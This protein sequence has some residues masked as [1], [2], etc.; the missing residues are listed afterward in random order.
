MLA[1]CEGEWLSGWGLFLFVFFFFFKRCKRKGEGIVTDRGS[2]MGD[3]STW[4][5][6]W[7]LNMYYTSYESAWLSDSFIVSTKSKGTGSAQ[8]LL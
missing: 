1:G 4:G 2:G 5:T 8:R 3:V 6:G 7:I